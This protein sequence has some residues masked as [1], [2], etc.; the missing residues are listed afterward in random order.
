MEIVTEEKY[1]YYLRTTINE[2]EEYAR[3]IIVFESVKKTM[4]TNLCLAKI[5]NE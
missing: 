3:E 1:Y 2:F 5:V 4:D